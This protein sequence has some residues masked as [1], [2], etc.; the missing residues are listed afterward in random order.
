MYSVHDRCCFSIINI[1]L[2]TT[3]HMTMC[4]WYTARSDKH[5]ANCHPTAQSPSDLFSI[6][7]CFGLLFWLHGPQMY[8]FGSPLSSVSFI[9]TAGSYFQQKALINPL[10]ATQGSI[11]HLKS[12]IFPAR[13]GGVQNGVQNI[14]LCLLGARMPC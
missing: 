5:T 8:C 3:H 6:S 2:S 14:A 12:W 9:I 10:K 13:V 11:Y 1:F 4:L 7:V